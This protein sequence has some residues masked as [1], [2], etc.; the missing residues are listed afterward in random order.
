MFALHSTPHYNNAQ[1]VPF[2]G[3]S[4]QLRGID[5]DVDNCQITKS[6]R[7]LTIDET[8]CLI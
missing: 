7:S 5:T 3:Y 4:V 6:D 8:A 2:Y 1:L